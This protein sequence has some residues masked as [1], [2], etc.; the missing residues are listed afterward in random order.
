MNNTPSSK[1]IG[2]FPLAILCS[3]SQG[4]SMLPYLLFSALAIAKPGNADFFVPIVVAYTVQRA[5]LVS[6]RGLGEITNPYRIMK[7]GLVL[8][9]IGAVL[10]FFSPLCKPL[11]TSGALFIGIGFSSLGA[12]FSLCTG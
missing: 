10:L 12:S 9:L 1:K 6:L 3:L 8:S 7:F 5:A 2:R 4:H 11:E